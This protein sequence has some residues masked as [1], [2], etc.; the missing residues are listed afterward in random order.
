M[1][2]KLFS[3]IFFSWTFSA[4][5]SKPWEDL[6]NL[7]CS[8]EFHSLVQKENWISQNYKQHVS[9]SPKVKVYRNF[10]STIGVWHELHLSENEAPVIYKVNDNELMKLSFNKQCGVIETKEQWPYEV[11]SFLSNQKEEDFTNASLKS[12]ISSGKSGWIYFWSPKYTYSV[13]DMP[14]VERMAKE[15]KMEFIPVVD[16]RAT[17]AEIE[18]ALDVLKSQDKEASK[19][20]SLASESA[21][22]KNMSTDLYMRNGLNH[23]PVIYVYSKNKIP[24]RYITGVMTRE[25]LRSMSSTF[26]KELK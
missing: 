7:K 13:T 11:A 9:M 15:F 5:A 6:K 2:L 1:T 18:G 20:R 24:D 14:R 25:G 21:M 23:F 10:S 3:L 12:V 17:Q 19:L 8:T 22:K 26:I 16:P 4:Q